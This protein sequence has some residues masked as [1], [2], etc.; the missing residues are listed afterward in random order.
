MLPVPLE[1]ATRGDPLEP[2]V[3]EGGGIVEQ[4]GEDTPSPLYLLIPSSGEVEEE[5]SEGSE[6]AREEQIEAEV[7]RRTE[8]RVLEL[9]D[10]TGESRRGLREGD[11]WREEPAPLPPTGNPEEEEVPRGTQGPLL[12]HAGGP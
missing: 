1:E 11:P 5:S 10:P 12:G 3:E 9:L 7:Q 8:A 6:A 2:I 4:D